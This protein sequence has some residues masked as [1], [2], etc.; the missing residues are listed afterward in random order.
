MVQGCVE[1]I[2]LN[3]QGK[4]KTVVRKKEEPDSKKGTHDLAA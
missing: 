1:G 2:T 3:G 4:S